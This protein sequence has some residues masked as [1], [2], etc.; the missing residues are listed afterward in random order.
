MSLKYKVYP[1]RQLLVDVLEGELHISDIL[2]INTAES[3][4]V[5]F[6]KIN[7]SITDLRKARLRLSLK[8]VKD[9]IKLLQP[10]NTNTD[11]KWAV[12]THNQIQTI[13][14]MML[15]ID[16]RYKDTVRVFP[17]VNDCNNFLGINYS[18]EEF[19]DDDFV[20]VK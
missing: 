2:K 4:N 3:K 8:E 1:E 13:L 17:T 14:A 16:S 15:R 5:D 9:F 10:A 11:A 20:F 7:K 12:L 19:G 18:E 6:S